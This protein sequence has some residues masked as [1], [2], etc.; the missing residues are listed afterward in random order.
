LNGRTYVW[1]ATI[2]VWEE[3]RI[4]GY[5][6][7]LWSEEFRARYGEFFAFA[8]QAHNQFIQSL[9]ESGLVGLGALVVYFLTMLVVAMKTSERTAGLSLACF[10][11]IAV[12]LLT[13][14]A[15]RTYRVD[16]AFMLHVFLLYVLVVA[17][18]ERTQTVEETS[19]ERRPATEPVVAA[20]PA[21]Q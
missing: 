6:P 17:W 13:E 12:R 18:A 3:S 8:G 16:A 15:L 7:T 14:A 10:S 1:D 20:R 19:E 11:L 5:G 21:L 4:F 9:G 2:E